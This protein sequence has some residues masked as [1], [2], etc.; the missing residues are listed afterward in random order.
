MRKF[1]PTFDFA[2]YRVNDINLDTRYLF[3]DAFLFLVSISPIRDPEKEINLEFVTT[4]GGE[5][6][7]FRRFLKSL[8]LSWADKFDELAIGRVFAMK[9]R[10]AKPDD[11][12]DL[13]YASACL[14]TDRR[15][16][17]AASAYAA[18]CAAEEEADAAM[19]AYLRTGIEAYS[20]KAAR[21][22]A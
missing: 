20:R 7:R 19:E 12:A 1:R 22:A 14:Q 8:R 18:E 9:N 6:P 11:F 17:E 13:E 3:D 4:D 16:F 2:A 5:G 10:G 21:R 15:A